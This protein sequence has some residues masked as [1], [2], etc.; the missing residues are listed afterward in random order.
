MKE[1]LITIGLT[2]A[3]GTVLLSLLVGFWIIL[4]CKS[5]RYDESK[6]PDTCVKINQIFRLTK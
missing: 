4:E 1:T 6:R 3:T 5:F 2:V